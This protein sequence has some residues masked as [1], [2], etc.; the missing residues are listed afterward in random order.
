MGYKERWYLIPRPLIWEQL[1]LLHESACVLKYLMG[2]Q[3][4]HSPIK[5][6]LT[7]VSQ[8]MKTFVSDSEL[9]QGKSE[10]HIK[11]ITVQR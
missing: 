4:I 11:H 5:V 7:A 2:N 6:L 1:N 3:K 8:A 10:W 9:A